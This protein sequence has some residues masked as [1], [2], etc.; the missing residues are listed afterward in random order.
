M[1]LRR[2]AGSRQWQ[3]KIV[4]PPQPAVLRINPSLPDQ[5]CRV[6][7]LQLRLRPQALH[8][9][10]WVKA[11]KSMLQQTSVLMLWTPR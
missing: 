9:L 7:R 3:R 8:F 10:Q 4:R 6:Q 5:P 1:A 2:T 11:D